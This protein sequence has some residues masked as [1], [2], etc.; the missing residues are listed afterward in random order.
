LPPTNDHFASFAEQ[1]MDM[2]SQPKFEFTLSDQFLHLPAAPIVEAVISLR[3]RANESLELEEFRAA[4]TARLPEYPD[5]KSQH[6]LQLEAH[7]DSD[8]GKMKQ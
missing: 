6:E 4:L 7:F 1:D 3:A 8:G 2:M 5:A